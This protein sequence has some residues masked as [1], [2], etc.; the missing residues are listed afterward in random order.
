MAAAVLIV[1]AVVVIAA[2]LL[3]Y[4]GPG[5]HRVLSIAEQK[6]SIALGSTVRAESFGVHL[7]GTSPIVDLYSVVVQ[8]AEP[9]PNPPL[10][11]IQHLRLGLHI[12]S[13]TQ[14]KWYLNEITIDQPVARIFVD[15]QGHNNLPQTGGGKKGGGN[16][17]DMGIR[18]LRL[19]RGEALY[20]NRKSVLNAD[21]RDVNFQAAFDTSTRS[22]S[23]DLSYSDGRIQFDKY[24]PLPHDLRARFTA[25]PSQFVLRRAVLT[26]G[27]SQFVLT[28]TL[29]DYS[30]PHVQAQYDAD[31]NTRELAAVL[32]NPSLPVGTLRLSG[33]MNYASE[34]NQPLLKTATLRGNLSSSSLLVRSPS[35]QGDIRDL[36]ANYLLRDGKLYVSDLRGQV[37]GGAVTGTGTLAL[38]G[39]ARSQLQLKLQGASLAE[40]KAAAK[41]SG[42]ED[43]GLSG[44]ADLN[45]NANWGKDLNSLVA[46]VTGTASGKLTPTVGAATVPVTAN[47]QARY[48]AANKQLTLGPSYLRTPH[49]SLNLSGVLARGSAIAVQMRAADLSEL[50]SLVPSPS[51]QQLGLFGSGAFNGTVRQS[52]QG[53][54]LSGQ[55]SA[56]NL[57][58]RGSQWRSLRANISASPS[59]LSVQNAVL[60]SLTGGQI[61]FR[62]STGLKDWSPTKTSPMELTLKATNV[63]T[64]SLEGLVGKQLPA[65]GILA[66]NLSFHGS[67]ESPVGQGTI[68][69]K[70]AKIAN[71]PVRQASL[72]FQANGQIVDGRLVLDTA[73]GAAQA[74]FSLNPRQETYDAQLRAVGIQLG[75][76]QALK[77]RGID[78][79]GVLNF[80]AGGRGTFSNPAL[81]LS[82]EIPKLQV[83]GQIIS[84]LSLQGTVADHVA[85]V[86]LDSQVAETF[87]R[88]HASVNLTGD[89]NANAT[90]DTQAIPLQ[91]LIALYAPAQAADITGQTEVHATLNGPLK[92]MRQVRAQVVVPTFTLSYKNAVQLGAASP[93]RIDYSDGVLA[94]QRTIIRGAGTDLQVQAT[95]PTYGTAPSSLAV[96]GTVNLRLVQVLYP[97]V[98]SSGQLRFD[99]N[100]YGQTRVP[101][102]QGQV[103][104]INANF[105]STSVPVGLQNGNGV[106]TLMQDRLD[107][108]QFEGI[109]GGGRLTLRG[110]L[111]YRPAISFDLVASGRGI[112]MLYP[113]G[114]RQTLNT[115]LTLTGAPQSAR[116]QGD[117]RIE[118]L[119]FTPDFDLMDF[120]GQF[121]GPSVAPPTRGFAQNLQL[122]IDL[123]STTGI[124]AVSRELSLQGTANL[125]VQGTAAQPVVLGRV[126]ISGGDLIFMSNRYELQTSTIDLVNPAQTQAVVNVAATTT[127]QQY[128]I[129]L[130]FV[131]PADRL[132]TTYTSD[133]SLPPSD[134]LNLLAFGKTTEASAAN[135][136]PGSLS[137][138]STIASQVS[139]Q[140]TSRVEKIAGISQLSIDP[141]LGTYTGKNPGARI[142]IQQRVTG[143]LF[144]T[145]ATDVTSTQRQVIQGQYKFSPRTSISVTRDQN[146]GF[147]F[148]TRIHKTW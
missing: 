58:V 121:G 92:N 35:F 30:H 122:D 147:G 144:V 26:S 141:V 127:I 77:A 131:G 128:N 3:L 102:L 47:I 31:L 79:N 120:M 76:L 93:V 8:G 143:N 13:L 108:T 100:S 66:A 78:A 125:H 34:P 83:A 62:I 6:A 16:I 38:T 57:R 59:N 132:R 63:R 111:V 20:N 106:L 71:Q 50:A 114:I 109:V 4:T 107:I 24:N 49:M 19:N 94:L 14:G 28:A 39:T 37:L 67:Q 135:P 137:A 52:A 15:K 42:A 54:A 43:L 25:S 72:D 91:P 1:I 12:V 45:V 53:P 41:A 65:S 116:L 81:Q 119:S 86:S 117:V 105:A 56:T 55:L 21:L 136:T 142:T 140:V 104:I 36:R 48:N 44:A 118:Q 126:N 46:N 148:D 130:R 70:Q 11:T 95:V 99:I 17:F 22:Y 33:S 68:S 112:R 29:T 84:N 101:N 9:Y 110:G 85:K 146:G 145:F 74:V 60:Q 98:T 103:H 97:D 139:G 27:R 113:E 64:T 123:A 124:N 96:L 10:L 80:T 61:A 129:Q 138:E 89:F 40:L 88:A 133:P 32:K 87:A 18:H 82:L 115:D 23:G 7:S 75:Q 90:L 5:K 69:L 134:I 73:A 2:V 51:V